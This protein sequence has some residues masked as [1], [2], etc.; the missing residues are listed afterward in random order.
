VISYCIKEDK[1][2]LT[3]LSEKELF[4]K[5]SCKRV[6]EYSTYTI[7]QLGELNPMTFN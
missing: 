2:Y 4:A 5:Q 6:A 7:E 1:N 3:N